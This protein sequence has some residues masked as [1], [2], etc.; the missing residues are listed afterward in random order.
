MQWN[1]GLDNYSFRNLENEAV[2][3]AT[4]NVLARFAVAPLATPANVQAQ[5]AGQAINLTWTPS[6]G[7]TSFNIYRSQTPASQGT[8]PYR[9]GLSA[10]SFSDTAP[11]S[12]TNYYVVTAANSATESAQSAEVSAVVATT[13]C[14][15][16]NWVSGT[17]YAA[18]SIVTYTDGNLY[19]A[20]F[21][22]PG[23]IPTVSTFFW[24]AFVCVAT[25]PPQACSFPNWVSVT[26]YAVGSIVTYTDG[27]L[28]RA[29]FANPGY[30]PTVSTFFWERFIC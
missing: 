6:A 12:G 21:A 22:N 25:P 11:A 19:R 27:N 28:Y 13:S 30:I 24:E 8:T 9:T 4:R 5:P 15:F 17:P 10:A 23:Y 16:P 20:K 29:K 26:Q 18:G 2:K 3:Q 7:A 14:S 1:W